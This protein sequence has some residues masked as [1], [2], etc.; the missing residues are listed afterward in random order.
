MVVLRLFFSFFKVGLFA[1]GGAYAFLPLM[2]KEIVDYHHWLDKSEF[3]EVLGLVKIFPGAISIK[4]ATYTGY[5]IAGVPGVIAANAGNLLAPIVLI[6][7]A[8]YLYS[9]YKDRSG[10]EAAFTMIQYAIFAMIIAVAFQLVDKSGLREP[11]YLAVVVVA[12][13]LFVFTRTH[14][15]LIIIGAGLAGALLG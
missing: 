12:F 14:P 4:F 10:F 6:L 1:I 15:A 7:S 8:T 3:L 11:K 9:R 2:E 5:K 13:V